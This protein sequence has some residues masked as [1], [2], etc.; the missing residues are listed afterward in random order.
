MDNWRGLMWCAVPYFL[1]IAIG[2]IDRTWVSLVLGFVAGILGC[3]VNSRV[4]ELLRIE[5]QWKQHRDY[6]ISMQMEP[7]K[8]HR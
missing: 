6:A 7:A 4:K 3:I 5:K 2:D 1:G 8:F